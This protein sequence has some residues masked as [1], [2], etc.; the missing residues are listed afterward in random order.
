MDINIAELRSKP[1]INF[2]VQL[3][4]MQKMTNEELRAWEDATV[5]KIKEYI[6]LEKRAITN[7]EVIAR[8][9]DSARMVE[10][11]YILINAY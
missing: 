2:S 8:L 6:Q 10:R 4:W 7:E 1:Q 5:E 3:K 11:D 9:K